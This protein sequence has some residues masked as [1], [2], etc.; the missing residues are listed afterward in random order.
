MKLQKIFAPFLISLT[1]FATGAE[2]Y[3]DVL[4]DPYDNSFYNNNSSECTVEQKTR[5][6]TVSKNSALYKAPGSDVKTRDIYAGE[7]LSCNTY[8]TDEDDVSWGYAY[9]GDN[10][11]GGWF[12]L[13]IAEVIYDHVSFVEEHEEE[14]TEYSGEL[15]DLPYE[16]NIFVW[17]YPGSAGLVTA[18]PPDSWLPVQYGTKQEQLEYS[19]KY[20]YTDSNGDKWVY[21]VTKGDGWLYVPDP[22]ADLRQEG[23]ASEETYVS[24]NIEAYGRVT[25]IP[26]GNIRGNDGA[27]F[28]LPVLLAVC[29]AAA[30]GAVIGFSRK[31]GGQ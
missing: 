21:V 12:K 26:G 30:S 6:Y 27:D 25:D 9:A 18:L 1:V 15:G 28:C 17:E 29:A 8:Y 7:V 16:E 23:S 2:V 19:A 11:K 20:V 24:E 14:L 5:R 13:K 10:G 4:I 22:C 3:A 31:K